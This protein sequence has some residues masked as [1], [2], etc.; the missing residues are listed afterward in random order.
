MTEKDKKPKE[1]WLEED[2]EGVLFPSPGESPLF[3][4][5]ELLRPHDIRALEEAEKVE[6]IVQDDTLDEPAKI[7]AIAEVRN[8]FSGSTETIDAFLAG[9]IDTETAVTKLAVP[10]E[11]AYSTADYGRAYYH[12]EMT[13]RS[14]R[15]VYSP[16]KAL[17]LWGP[18]E[19]WPEPSLPANENENETE[20]ESTE[21]STEGHLW[22]LWYAILHAAKRIPWTDTVEQERLLALVQALKQRPDP[23]PPSPMTTPLKRNWIW[24]DGTLWSTLSMLGPSAR[25]AWND[26][27]G[28]GAGWTVPEQHAWTSVNAF[29]A[30]LVA[31]GTSG[32]LALYGDWALG[33]A[34]E[35]VPRSAGLHVKAAAATQLAVKVT[36]A[37]VWIQIAGR[38]MW[39][40][41]TDEGVPP[42][43]R[44]ADLGARENKLP[45]YGRK[46]GAEEAR[47]C[48][49]RWDFWRRRL[50][51]E[52]ENG[53]L[54]EEVRELA[55][56]SAEVIGKFFEGY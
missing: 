52:G 48:T 24:E 47:R 17:E 11:K 5:P 10:I 36:V 4:G 35:T 3:D 37:C 55:R 44:V 20:T 2:G 14:Q 51:Q 31:S 39:N 16:E 19:D 15:P 42:D 29:V 6:A 26:C 27:C 13:A 28:C 41:R 25:E 33:D 8:W 54:P 1:E 34:V 46:K 56:G 21:G 22:S 30:R 9:D 43:L 49:V 12:A 53:E 50:E 40:L 7:D 45:W 38:Y 18:E 32:A 23:P